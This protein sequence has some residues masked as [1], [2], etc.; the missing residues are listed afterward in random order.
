M[1]NPTTSGCNYVNKVDSLQTTYVA[2]KSSSGGAA[3]GFAWLFF[4]T[5]IAL[6]AYCYMLMKKT[7]KKIGMLGSDGFA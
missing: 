7:G 5:T 4:F 6:A 2:P 3:K 1:A